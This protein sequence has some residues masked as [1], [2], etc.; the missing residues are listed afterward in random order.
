MN[1]QEQQRQRQLQNILWMT[2]IFSIL[3]FGYL[4]HTQQKLIEEEPAAVSFQLLQAIAI[5]PLF[6]AFVVRRLMP[7]AIAKNMA[8]QSITTSAI[9]VLHVP[10]ILSWVCIES[11]LILGGFLPATTHHNINY[12][13]PPLIV[14]LLAMA[15]LR[16]HKSEEVEIQKIL[17]KNSASK[18]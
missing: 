18:I 17:S 7:K 8:R 12:F 11:S 6:F 5:I 3:I 1:L 13:F 9:Q 2:L 16:P 4:L 10:R 14:S 15:I